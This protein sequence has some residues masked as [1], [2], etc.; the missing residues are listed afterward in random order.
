MRTLGAMV[1]AL[2]CSGLAADA[3]TIVVEA[4]PSSRNARIIV[5]HDGIP[6]GNTHLSITVQGQDGLRELASDPNGTAMLKDLPI[7]TTC[8][9]ATSKNNL[10]ADLC[11][12]VSKQSPREISSFNMS[13]LP[14]APPPPSMEDLIRA[15]EKTLPLERV[16][17]LDGIVQDPSGAV[18]PNAI[19][20][21]YK[22]GSYP[23]GLL[24]KLRTNQEGR[25][26]VSLNPG[27]YTA[28]VQMPGFRTDFV[29]IEISP[30]NQVGEVRK[31]LQI[32]PTSTCP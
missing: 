31:I 2:T 30:E 4:R 26:A 19:V 24:S 9:L 8:I 29:I 25:F 22:R 28:I 11:L 7:G 12:E 27:S 10:R 16:R 23:Q 5:L 32:G 14:G 6:Q 15:A 20:D 21:I 17:K 3:C 13:L 1:L 18:I